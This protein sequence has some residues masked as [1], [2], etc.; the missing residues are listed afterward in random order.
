VLLV[1]WVLLVVGLQMRSVGSLVL[2]GCGICCG[3]GEE[4]GLEGKLKQG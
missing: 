1:G 4:V 2:F 3:V